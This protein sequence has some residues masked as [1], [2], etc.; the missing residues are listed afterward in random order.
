MRGRLDEADLYRGALND[1]GRAIARVVDYVARGRGT[2][3][4]R[5]ALAWLLGRRPAPIPIVGARWLAQLEDDLGAVDVSLDEDERERL[6]ELTRPD[7]GFPHEFLASEP[8]RQMVY[9][10]THGR[11]VR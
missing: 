7:P 2:S 11:I 8:V 10:G 3:P 4:A 9:G 5:V 6:D 1:R